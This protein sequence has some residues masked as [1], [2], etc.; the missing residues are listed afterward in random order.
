MIV[1]GLTGGIG[2]G[3]STIKQVFEILHVPVFE[4]DKE[5][6]A[7]LQDA[8][9]VAKL[10]DVFGADVISQNGEVDRKRLASIVFSNKDQLSVLNGIIHPA[11]RDKFKRWKDAHCHSPYVINEAAILFE[12]GLNLHV[13]CSINVS[14]PA[15]IRIERVILRDKIDK[16][17]VLDR[18][19]NQMSDDQ[20][21][22]LATWTIINDGK[23]PVIPQILKIDGQLRNKIE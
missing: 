12:S 19:A 13:D 8:G 21:K 18:I 10:K 23:C 16:K 9:V 4:S 3:K 14:A 2:S 17:Q 11:V 5:G 20:R 22:M 1:V 6:H 7:V 15:D